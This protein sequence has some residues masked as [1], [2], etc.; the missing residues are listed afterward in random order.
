M[1]EK[2]DYYELLGVSRSANTDEI[3]KAYRQLARKYHPDVNKED[4]QAAD[5][6]KQFTE[7]YAV[8]SDEQ[9]R[10]AYDQYGHAAF[11]S[12]QGGFGGFGGFD[13][14]M[15]EFGFG[16]LFD[17]FFGGNVGGRGRRGG[18]RRGADRE[19]RVDIN[20]EDALFGIEK[21]LE[22]SRS[23]TC[24]HCGGSRAE[25]GSKTK[26]CP[27]CNGK[28]QVRS[29]QSTPFGR[30]E[31][32]RPCNQ[33]R[34]E[35]RII[36]KP[37]TRCRGTGQER[38]T[39]KINVR[40]PAGIDTGSRLRI[41]GE[42][43]IG[44]QGGPPGDLY[45]LIAVKSHPRFKR[46]GYNLITDLEISFVQASLGADLSIDL[47]GGAVHNL[48]IPEGTQP[49]TVI[50]SKGKGVAHIQGHRI[51]DLKV[52][53][54]VKIPTRLSKKQRQLLEAFYE[55]GEEQ[56]TGRKGIFDK[57]KDVIG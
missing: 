51:G 55:E 35:G 21:D 4:P 5:K 40:V 25:P 57:F 1:P 47:P 34:G 38:K 30:F 49:G 13:F 6:F 11:E 50:T 18:P 56:K 28:G 19:V 12:G 10:A 43:E 36:E 44:S 2:R 24:E 31:T 45:I 17:V 9:K 41:Q 54:E 37:C 23:E 15:S 27:T 39:R 16:D 32:V 42:G 46:D 29:V 26:T 22:L 14:D 8:L 33:C 52:N 3:K 20:F 48:H 7:A 53:I